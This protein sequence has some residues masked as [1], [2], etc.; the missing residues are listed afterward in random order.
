MTARAVPRVWIPWRRVWRPASAA[1]GI[2]S[3]LSVS[4][5]SCRLA[6]SQP[7]DRH[8]ALA[9]VRSTSEATSNRLTVLIGPVRTDVRADSSVC[10]WRNHEK[11]QLCLA[12]A[13]ALLLGGTSAVAKPIAFA[14]GTTVMAEY[15]AGTMKEAQVFYAPKYFLSLGAG[16][17]RAR[18]R[19][20][21]PAARDHLRAR[22]LPREALEHGRPP[23]PTCSCGAAR[24][25]PT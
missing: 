8:R 2:T 17:S 24:V 15:G 22:Q 13:G 20:R 21:S 14:H 25:R 9:R 1:A 16:I 19:H 11:D 10:V 12:V 5:G 18:E 23:R 4:P 6:S 3:S 7:P